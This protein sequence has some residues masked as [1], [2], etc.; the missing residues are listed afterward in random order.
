MFCL[1]FFSLPGACLVSAFAYL[2]FQDRVLLDSAL[3]RRTNVS[4]PNLNLIETLLKCED[5][6]D[7]LERIDGRKISLEEFNQK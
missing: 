5:M 2:T 6:V 4:Q 7:T 3:Q 1:C